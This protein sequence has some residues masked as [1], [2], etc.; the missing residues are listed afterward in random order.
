ASLW[1]QPQGL[2]RELPR[3]LCS[4]QQ[5][6]CAPRPPA[7]GA[8]GPIGA[9]SSWDFH[10]SATSAA[11]SSSVGYMGLVRRLEVASAAAATSSSSSVMP[12]TSTAT[13]TTTKATTTTAT[14]TTTTMLLNTLKTST[15]T[16]MASPTLTTSSTSAVVDEVPSSSPPIEPD[17]KTMSNND[18]DERS[19]LTKFSFPVILLACILAV[20]CT[21]VIVVPF[22]L[23]LLVCYRTAMN[24]L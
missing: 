4:A 22:S 11:A 2:L 12:E 3:K 10:S 19:F 15:E 8:T 24:G 7:S 18:V 5:I 14:T 17:K 13:A 6:R 16:A 20:F 9:S 21:I 23:C 1:A